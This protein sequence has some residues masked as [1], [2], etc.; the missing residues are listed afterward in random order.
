MLLLFTFILS[1]LFGWAYVHYF[2]HW[3]ANPKL[4]MSNSLKMIL[5]IITFPIVISASGVLTILLFK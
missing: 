2:I 3:L 1:C 4:N 5:I